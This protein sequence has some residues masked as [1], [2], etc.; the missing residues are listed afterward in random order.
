MNYDLSRQQFLAKDVV[1]NAINFFSSGAGG[2]DHQRW[3][4]EFVAAFA[5]ELD[6][7]A[8][9]FKHPS[10][11]SIW[12]NAQKRPAT[13]YAKSACFKGFSLFRRVSPNTKI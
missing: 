5:W 1:S 8:C 3:A 11:A 10:F 9:M 7:F 2:R 6:I 12:R 13:G 4:N